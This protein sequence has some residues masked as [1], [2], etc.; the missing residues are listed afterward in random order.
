MKSTNTLGND[1]RGLRKFLRSQKI[2]PNVANMERI[3]RELRRTDAQNAA[4]VARSKERARETGAPVT[5]DAKGA[6]EP[7]VRALMER[8]LRERG[9]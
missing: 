8:K 2:Q 1:D 9:S 7:R 5:F 6:V 3:G 4:L